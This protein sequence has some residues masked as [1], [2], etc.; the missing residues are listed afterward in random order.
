MQVSDEKEPHP[1]E[2]VHDD[3]V[4]ECKLE[5][6]RLDI[7][8]CVAEKISLEHLN[9]EDDEKESSMGETQTNKN[10]DSSPETAQQHTIAQEAKPRTKPSLLS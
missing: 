2:Y 6:T 8:T 1:L 9:S 5:Q 10:A 3:D 4:M 7:E